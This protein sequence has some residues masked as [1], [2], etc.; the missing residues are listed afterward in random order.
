[1]KFRSLFK[2][3]GLGVNLLASFCFIMLAVYGWG[4]EWSELGQY[5]LVLIILLGG[6]IGFA[7]LMG[8]SLRQF[9]K[10]RDRDKQNLP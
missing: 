10:W 5:L 3:R 1:M 6:L 2:H 9:M 8:W 4:M 7:A